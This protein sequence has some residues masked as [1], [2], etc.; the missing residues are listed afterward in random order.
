MCVL[1]GLELLCADCH[2]WQHIGR[3]FSVLGKEQR[4]KMIEHFCRVNECEVNDY[5]KYMIDRQLKR[6]ESIKEEVDKDCYPLE[7][8]FLLVGDIPFKQE[9]IKKLK[10]KG[11]YANIN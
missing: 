4:E 7:V 10:D 6:I 2:N 5:R 3:S 1:K 9:I 8:K 11:V